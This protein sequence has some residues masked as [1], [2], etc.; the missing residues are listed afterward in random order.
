MTG[1]SNLSPELPLRI[2]CPVWKCEAWGGSVYPEKTPQRAWL[3]WY[4]RMFNTVEGN[5]SFYA[6]PSLQSARRWAED[7]AEGFQFC[8]KFPRSISHE[9]A[10]QSAVRETE[11]FLEVLAVLAEHG[12][13]GPAFLQLG[14]NFG[15]EQLP[16]LDRYLRSLPRDYPFAVEVRNLGWFDSAANEQ[17]L[18]ALLG[19]LEID[20]VLFDSRP[21]YQSPPDDDVERIS[22]TR[23]PKTPLRRT[24]TGAQPMIRL[25]GRNKIELVDAFV[26]DWLPSISQWLQQGLRPIVFTHAPDDRFAPDLARRFANQLADYLEQHPIAGLSMAGLPQLPTK[27]KQL[28]LF[29][30]FD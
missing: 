13:L 21:L 25:V 30:S 12:R 24:V 1:F 9:R 17:R 6:I 23:K 16:I 18:D 20:K 11:H 26:A 28:G 4:S 22:Q 10:L 3:H 15:P 27:P 19:E 8:M 5:S 14:P 29:G 2:G 7:S